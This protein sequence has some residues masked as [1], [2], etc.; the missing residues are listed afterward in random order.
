MNQTDVK[1]VLQT[2]LA[3]DIDATDGKTKYDAQIKKVL[4]NKIIHS[5]RADSSKFSV[6]Q[7]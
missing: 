6:L 2:P 5:Y 7:K 4:S 1:N 3:N